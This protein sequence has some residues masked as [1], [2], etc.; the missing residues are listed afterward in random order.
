[1]TKQKSSPL[2]TDGGASAKSAQRLAPSEALER[3]TETHWQLPTYLNIL[4][5]PRS[6]TAI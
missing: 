3:G 1:M 4:L 2:V 5:L 6:L